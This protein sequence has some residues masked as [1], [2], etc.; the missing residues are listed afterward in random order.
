MVK[1]YVLSK[2]FTRQT[3]LSPPHYTGISLTS[4]FCV[5]MMGL[6]LKLILLEI[7]GVDNRFCEDRSVGG[8][9]ELYSA[10]PPIFAVAYYV[11]CISY[12][13][14]CGMPVRFTLY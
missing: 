4:L 2:Q 5:Q 3:L 12:V 9:A 10:A 14:A 1:R 8:A 6:R 11:S 13:C 7:L